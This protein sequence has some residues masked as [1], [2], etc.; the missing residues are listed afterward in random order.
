V[1]GVPH[2]LWFATTPTEVQL[3]GQPHRNIA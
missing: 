1:S 2:F 3:L